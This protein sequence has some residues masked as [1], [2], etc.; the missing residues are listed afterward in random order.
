M[1]RSG[2]EWSAMRGSEK[3]LDCFWKV[4]QKS[5]TRRQVFGRAKGYTGFAFRD[6]EV[7]KFLNFAKNKTKMLKLANAQTVCIFVL[8][9]NPET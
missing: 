4:R 1:K 5:P 8:T 2:I 9:Q 3:Q 7:L 6:Y